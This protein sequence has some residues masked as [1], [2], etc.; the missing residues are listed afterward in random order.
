MKS[1]YLLI[2]KRNLRRWYELESEWQEAGLVCQLPKISWEGN[3][4]E[5]LKILPHSDFRALALSNRPALNA[6]NCLYT[7]WPEWARKLPY[8]EF[9]FL[10][11]FV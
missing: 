6:L 8:R 4:E 11:F 1:S 5:M 9:G 3:E 10:R 7:V 2:L